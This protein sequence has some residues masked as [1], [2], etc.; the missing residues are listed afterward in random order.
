MQ[1]PLLNTIQTA[2]KKF[3]TQARPFLIG[4]SDMNDYVC[5]YGSGTGFAKRLFCEYI[6]AQYMRNWDLPIP[7]YAFI[8]VNPEHIPTNFSLSNNI[9][10]Q[11]CFGLKYNRN[12]TEL[13][14]LNELFIVQ[15]FKNQLF[16]SNLLKVALFDCWLANEDRNSNNYNLMFELQKNY[17]LIAIDHEGIFN[18]RIFDNPIYALNNDDTLLNSSFAQQLF[19]KK[20]LNNNAIEELRTYFY[21]CIEKCENNSKSILSHVPTNWQIDN[22]LVN[23]KLAEI[24]SKKWKQ[25]T[26]DTFNV[27]VHNL[28]NTL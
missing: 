28:L 8:E 18:T 27:F 4:C 11:T 23:K 6:G 9:F 24:F 25:E 14:K 22:E 17:Q 10:N 12:Y 2:D 1:V 13:T 20:D 3:D 19:N 7:D 15:Q 26:F 21:I 5:K 16:K